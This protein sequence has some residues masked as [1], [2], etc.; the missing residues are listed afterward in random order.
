M[1]TAAADSEAAASLPRYSLP[2]DAEKIFGCSCDQGWGAFGCTQHVCPTG[3]D[4]L[5]LAQQR[6]SVVLRC[7]Y[8][9]SADVG[10]RIS[11]GGF[12]SDVIR[13]TMTGFDLRAA[14]E[15]VK[16]M[17]RVEVTILS[18]SGTASTVCD[19]A[20]GNGKSE[21][22]VK[23]MLAD[24]RSDF[25]PLLLKHEDGRQLDSILANK[26]VT[27]TGGQGLTRDGDGSVIT[28][29]VG[30]VESEPCSGRGTCL[31]T[32]DCKCH[33]GFGSSDGQ[34]RSGGKGD[35]GFAIKGADSITAC[36]GLVTASMIPCSGHGRCL[37][38][39]SWRCECDEGFGSGDCSVRS[40]PSGRSWF[41][42]PTA[43][44]D[45]AHTSAEC[46]DMGICSRETGMCKCRQGFSGAACDMMG[47]PGTLKSAEQGKLLQRE[48]RDALAARVPC[49]GHGK[50][51]TMRRLADF[52]EQNGVPVD[53]TYGLNRNDP[54]RWD[55]DA[56]RG[57]VCDQ[58]WTGYDCSQIAC[59]SGNDIANDKVQA[60]EIQTIKCVHQQGAPTFRLRFR[61]ATTAA[62]PHTSSPDQ[63]RAALEALGEIG[64]VDV[65]FGLQQAAP[66]EAC[67]PGGGTDITITFLTD[68]GDLPPVT[69]PALEGHSAAELAIDAVAAEARKGTTEVAECNDRG[70]CDTATGSCVCFPGWGASNGQGGAGVRNDCGF[71]VPYQA[72]PG[73]FLQRS[74]RRRVGGAG[75]E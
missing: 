13:P 3:D 51:L 75:Y 56:S 42:V 36:A 4:P 23:I 39:P 16:G 44:A 6:P 72:K 26:V 25:P 14:L 34:G 18:A 10:F 41:D 53:T 17:G 62:M 28:S 52:A 55:A 8:P 50:C 64:S 32:G 22:I 66:T 49:S 65:S 48:G 47:C 69:V 73:P 33:L 29:T 19:D 63:I 67:T 15:Q 21:A 45:S 59:E 70:V 60:T 12:A 30:T 31:D 27:A 11:R 9:V 74:L 7:D 43:A 38:A 46:S 20:D 40:C 61:G 5:T 2:W 37:G 24:Q 71:R 58:G 1:R 57:C 54:L 68:H 35:C